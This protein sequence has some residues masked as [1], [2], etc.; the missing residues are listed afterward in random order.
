MKSASHP[1]DCCLIS[2]LELHTV[3]KKLGNNQRVAV[4]MVTEGHF[5]K[6]HHTHLAG[7]ISVLLFIHL[8][9]LLLFV[10]AARL[11][12]LAVKTHKEG[13]SA[14][15]Q[16]S[17]L[18]AKSRSISLPR[19]RPGW[20]TRQQ[21]LRCCLFFL[22]I[23]ATPLPGGGKKNNNKITSIYNLGV[24]NSLQ[25]ICCRVDR[26]V[27]TLGSDSHHCAI[28]GIIMSFWLADYG[29]GR[30]GGGRFTQGGKSEKKGEE[31]CRKLMCE[32]KINHPSDSERTLPRQVVVA[33]AQLLVYY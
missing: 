23:L 1:S 25:I 3:K 8:F 5:E 11:R 9:I 31:K 7:L 6:K 21:R 19:A 27:G 20:R 16:L 4:V 13:I 29:L 32:L 30:G 15:W 10:C 14:A 33:S 12:A 18:S 26:A 28:N 17:R 2:H 22:S 24:L